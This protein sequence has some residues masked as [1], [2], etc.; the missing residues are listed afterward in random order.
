MRLL[1]LSLAFIAAICSCT[2]T[3]TKTETVTVKDTVYIYDTTTIP[4]LISDT[5]TT[6]IVVR[7]AEKESIGAD[8][9]LNTDGQARAEEL[10]RILGNVPVTTIYSTSFNRTR[11]TVQPLAT[12]KGVSISEYPT[13]KPIP[14]LVN[15]ILSANKGKVV[16]IVGHSNTVPDI[17]KELSKNT[18]TTP[19]ISESQY[20]RM[21]IISIPEKLTPTVTFLKYGKDTR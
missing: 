21:F 6:F 8:P 11:Q 4:A 2:K 20:D 15:V 17:V 18:Y 9:N 14:D 16:V 19:A 3:Q 5:T 7:H 1:L 12:A 13:L 10:K